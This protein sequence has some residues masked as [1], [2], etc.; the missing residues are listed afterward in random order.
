VLIAAGLPLVLLTLGLC[1]TLIISLP[2]LFAC[3]L[4]AALIISLAALFARALSL[5]PFGIALALALPL[6]LFAPCLVTVV[7]RALRA[8]APFALAGAV[9]FHRETG[10]LSLR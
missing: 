4:P 7:V 5:L 1:A 8:A 10:G 6:L 9:A 2:A 3:A